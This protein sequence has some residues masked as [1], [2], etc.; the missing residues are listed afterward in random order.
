MI[1]LAYGMAESLAG[2]RLAADDPAGLVPGQ[3]V[4]HHPPAAHRTSFH[5]RRHSSRGRQPERIMTRIIRIVS[6]M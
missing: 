1:A 3:D 4:G 6:R 5:H 2:V